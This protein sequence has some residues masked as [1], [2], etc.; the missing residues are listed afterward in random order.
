MLG[1]NAI[2]RL[3]DLWIRRLHLPRTPHTAFL[4]TV[5]L[6]VALMAQGTGLEPGRVVPERRAVSD[7]AQ[8]YALYLPSGYSPASQWPVLV[9]MDP[10]GRALVPLELLR[11][12]A[13]R[14]GYV[15]ISSYNTASDTDQ[16]VNVPAVNAMIADL[17][18]LIALDE[19]RIYLVGFSGTA[20]DGWLFARELRGHVAGLIGVGAGLSAGM[21]L[22]PPAPGDSASFV[23]FGGAGTTDFNHD[24]VRGLDQ[25]LDPVGIPH[26]VRYYEGPHAWPPADVMTEAVEWLELMA[27]RRRLIAARPEWVDS[28]YRRELAEAAR[29]ESGGDAYEAW[30]R[31]EAIAVDYAGLRP[32]DTVAVE[33]RR[34]AADRRVRRAVDRYREVDRAFA[35]YVDGLRQYLTRVRL[36]TKP[37]SQADGLKAIELRR[38]ARAAADTA[39]RIGALAAARLLEQAFVTLSFYEP[40]QW[41]D[42]GDGARAVALLDLAEAI[43]PGRPHV[44]TARRKALTLLGRTAEAEALSCQG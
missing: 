39:D 41:L 22:S 43:H 1:H 10:R 37:P 38:L 25:Y 7:S 19:R 13:E 3:G 11:P 17:Q 9:V 26:R 42:R 35:R 34:L 24:E 18:R 23:F 30:R 40:R 33:A 32:V 31:F 44:C 15:V 16:P 6:P 36:G 12:A 14:L 27:M 29:L 21:T 8:R 2:G 5:L 20:R 28:L 4:F